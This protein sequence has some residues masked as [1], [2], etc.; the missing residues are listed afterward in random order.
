MEDFDEIFADIAAQGK[1][2]EIAPKEKNIIA[3]GKEKR[4]SIR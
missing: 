1:S 2:E 3:D 4:R